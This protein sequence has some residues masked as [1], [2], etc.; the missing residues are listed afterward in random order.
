[1]SFRPR[2]SLFALALGL[3][4]G[5]CAEVRVDDDEPVGDQPDVEVRPTTGSESNPRLCKLDPARAGTWQAAG[6]PHEVLPHRLAATLGALFVASPH[7]LRRSTDGGQSFQV[8]DSPIAG[9]QPWLMAGL[10]ST[11]FVGVDDGAL[12]SDD[13]GETWAWVN[14]GLHGE[15]I[16]SFHR[17]KSSLLARS[18]GGSLVRWAAADAAWHE[19]DSGSSYA[20]GVAASDG[21]TVLVDTGAGVLR[22]TDLAA[23]SLVNGL[24]AWG[25]QDILVADQLGLAITASGEIRRSADAG[26]N[27]L[28]AQ[29]STLEIGVASR[30]LEHGDAMFALT[31]KGV[32]RSADGGASWG[33]ALADSPAA[34]VS[35]I[36]AAGDLLAV[37]L[38]SISVTS[39][40][41]ATWADA[42]TFT[43]STPIAFGK[44]GSSLLTSTDAAFV[45]VSDP[46]TPF[47]ETAASGY[48]LRDVEDVD[49]TTYLLFSQRQELAASYGTSWATRTSDGGESFET[50]QLPS[51]DDV[52]GRAFETIAVDGDVI[53]VGGIDA[54][55]GN[56]QGPGVWASD[57]GGASWS[58]A[59]EGLP[60]IDAT[61]DLYPAVLS[62]TKRGDAVLGLIDNEGVFET[63]DQGKS[64]QRVGG[65]LDVGFFQHSIDQLLVAGDTL[66]LWSRGDSPIVRST[67]AGWELVEWKDEPTGDIV[68][69]SAVGSTLIAARQTSPGNPGSGVYLS[70]DGGASWQPF[71]LKERVRSLFVDGETLW[72]GVEGQGTFS[73]DVGACR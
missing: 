11:L 73:L 3:S 7:A 39:D 20:A 19:V 23:W 6:G 1:M 62:L 46:L 35:E 34:G 59:S 29:Q 65:E 70:N 51:S 41:G 44:I 15:G 49:G 56:S 42:A 64:W 31:D 16:A 4:L 33:I 5:A 25:Y 9:P 45:F 60:A 26:V 22:S 21:K 17:G 13:H 2:G 72:A 10:D 32:V 71:G 61:A 8:I 69:L 30:V 63:R 55:N 12:Q 27:W 43:D 54:M 37:E 66:Y 24:E 68:A 18:T 50:I 58:R 52:Y 57:D 67:S 40:G 36:A 38:G 48:F 53:L 14:T 47:Q 28:P